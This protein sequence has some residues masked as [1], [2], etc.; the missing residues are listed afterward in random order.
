MSAWFPFYKFKA[1]LLRIFGAKVGVSLIIKPRVNIKYPWFLKIGD[2]VSIGE[3]VWIDNLGLVTI[4]D[5]VTISQ[6]AMLLTGNH[7]Y[8]QESFDLMISEISLES[9]AWV[10]AKA[11]VGPGVKLGRNAVLGM[12]SIALDDLLADSFYLGH[13]AVKIRD[14]IIA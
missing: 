3:D 2:Y 5:C 13:P 8:K 14:R 1:R 6:G 7:N 10:G 4:G 11:M 9:G 12:G